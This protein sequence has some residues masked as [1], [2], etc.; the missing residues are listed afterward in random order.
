MQLRKLLV[1]KTQKPLKFNFKKVKKNFLPQ[2]SLNKKKNKYKYN[3]K[4]IR[5]LRK[6]IMNSFIL[7]KSKNKTKI[8][9][10]IAKMKKYK[11]IN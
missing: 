6:I 10:K 11:N 9:T 4:T 1:Y 3:L 2:K 8:I 5:E 7:Q